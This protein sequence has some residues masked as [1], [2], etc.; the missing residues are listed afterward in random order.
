MRAPQFWWHRRRSLAAIGLTAPAWMWGGFAARRMQRRPAYWPPIPVICVGNFT[1]GGDGKTP[2][3]IEFGRIVVEMGLTP[4]FLTRGYGGSDSGPTLVKSG[5]SDPRFVGDEPLLLA[6]IG[7]T[8]VA[9]DRPS[10][11]RH[12]TDAGVDVIIMDDGFQTPSLG[13]DLNIAVI[14]SAVGLGNKMPVPAGPLRASLRSQ[15]AMT[16]VIVLVGDGVE[17]ARMVRLASRAGKRLLQAETSSLEPDK[18]TH[19]KILAYAGIGR[20]DKFFSAL[21]RCGGTFVGRSDFDDHHY[22]T[23]ADAKALLRHADAGAD[24]RLVTTEKDYARLAGADGA[25]AELRER[26][27][28]FAVR[29]RFD[30]ASEVRRLITT[31]VEA[32][33][34]GRSK[35]RSRLQS[36]RPFSL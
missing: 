15:L 5:I 6:E 4:G 19:G 32:V 34:I 18:W 23:E 36:D 25:V 3:A 21:E 30:S 16:D 8:I 24:I 35:R 2:T 1:I 10:G 14:D 31:T 9:R 33:R 13:R 26:S 22:Y 12:L 20:A 28:V 11:A 17:Q 29:L 27:E 7:P